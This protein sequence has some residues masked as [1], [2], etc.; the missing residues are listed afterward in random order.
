MKVA[1]LAWARLTAATEALSAGCILIIAGATLYEVVSRYVF[2]SPTL[3]AQDLS[4][5]AMIWC[6]FLGLAA[7]EQS[8]AHIRIDLWSAKIGPRS[9]AIIDCSSFALMALF[10]A[11]VAVTAAE[12]VIQ[13]VR[14]GRRSMSLLS[15]PMWIPQSALAAGAT[16]FTI[17]CLRRMASTRSPRH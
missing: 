12:I 2:D 13:S 4:V 17:E 14:Y 3:W 7:T 15:V 10:G 16:L 8:G 5:Y 11:V 1:A 9:K 6:T